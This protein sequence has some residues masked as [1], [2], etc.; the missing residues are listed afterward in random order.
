MPKS[1]CRLLALGSLVLAAPAFAQTLSLLDARVVEGSAG[2]ALLVFEAR[3][4]APASGTVRFDFATSDGSATY[5]STTASDDYRLVSLG[6]LS[7][8]AGQTQMLVSVPV[9]GDLEVE[10]N[11][12]LNAAIYNVSGATVARAAAKGLIVNDDNK[13]LVN[14]PLDPGAQTG[15]TGYANEFSALSGDGRYVAFVST[16]RDLVAGRPGNTVKNV[17]VRDTRTGITTLASVAADG[18]DTDG[19]STMPVLSDNGRYLAF[20][21]MATNIA[22]NDFNGGTDVFLRDLQTGTTTLVSVDASGTGP[23]AGWSSKPSMSANGRFVAFHSGGQLVAGID[24]YGRTQSYVRDVQAGTTVL[25]SRDPYGGPGA[26][27]EGG[28]APHLSSDGRYVSYDRNGSEPWRRD[29][30]AGTSTIAIFTYGSGP[31]GS[32]SYNYGISS[33]GRYVVFL[34]WSSN[35]TNQCSGTGGQIFVSD[36]QTRTTRCASMFS[37]GTPSYSAFYPSMSRDGRYVAYQA[38]GAAVGEPWD[39]YSR[40]FVRDM[41]ANTTTL[42]S[43]NAQGGPE[44]GDASEM[45]SI[46]ADGRVVSFV[47]YSTEMLPGDGNGEPDIFRVELPQDPSLPRISIADASV[48][49]GD[50]GTRQMVFTVSLSAPSASTVAFSASVGGGS[51][52]DAADYLPNAPTTY[53]PAGQTSATLAIEV[54]GDTTPELVETFNVYINGAYGAIV[55][56]GQAAGIIVNDDYP[57][58]PTLSIADQ[59]VVEGNSGTKLAYLTV[60][61]SSP[62]ATP[63][64]FDIATAN[65]TAQAGSDFVAATQ[66]LTIPAGSTSVDFGVA[67]IGDGVVESPETFNVTISNPVGATISRAM[68]FC[69]IA[70]DDSYPQISLNNFSI[71]EGN[72]GTKLATF[73]L[74]LS[75]PAASP[76]TYDIATSDGTAMAG[77][78]YVAR[79]LTGQVIP[80]GASSASFSVTV[81]G[82]TTIEDDETFFATL[83]NVAGATSGPAGQGRVTLLNDDHIESLVVLD[84]SVAEGNSGTRLATFTVQ[85]SNPTAAPVSFTIATADGTAIAPADYVA[86]SQSFQIP[87]G[88]QTASFAVTIN[89][90][91]AI[92]SN[93]TFLVNVSGVSGATVLDGQAVGTI[94]NDDVLPTLSIADVSISEGNNSSKNVTFMVS[95]SAA[96]SGTVSF[97]IATANGTAV[98]PGDYTAKTATAQTIPAGTL[99]KT[100][101]VSIKGDKQV[102][103]TESFFVNLSNVSGPVTLADGQ[104]IGTIVNDDGATLSVARVTTG[105]LYDDVDDHR[106]DPVLAPREYALL[107]LDAAQQVCARAGGATIVGIDGVESMAVLAD[108]ADTANRTC[109]RQPQYSA[110]LKANG[111]GFLVERGTQVLAVSGANARA[112]AATVLADGHARPLTVLLA[113]TPSSDARERAAQVGELNRLVRA[114][115]AAE[116]RARLVVLGATGIDGLVDLT[117]RSLPTAGGDAERIWVSPAMLE[118]FERVQLDIPGAPKS[119]PAQQVLQLQP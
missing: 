38:R 23:S 12:F 30:Q 61:L 112:S 104:A 96:A 76:V 89:G 50:S 75:S 9:N 46:S 97:N 114:R 119:K 1:I 80:V 34:S 17:Y 21:S 8:P 28:Y 19:D 70:N 93:E 27:P 90:D 58:P 86:K 47:S 103:P 35:L 81:N 32:N 7:I 42:A 2:D 94:T 92:E 33:D 18:G 117:A 36:L 55:A 43:F 66:T 88:A 20:Q 71:A 52:S 102:E 110:A 13:M 111:L 79:A 37:D 41:Q 67:I 56:D 73:T 98:A 24:T 4:S 107:L 83:S 11:E 78:D 31:I 101:T 57:P 22:A 106:G 62:S 49:E 100:F 118:E 25:A 84:A 29:L 82:D 87:A 69:T 91:T 116:P 16:G 99:G 85:L 45:A 72:S 64:S 15:S 40:I 74:T 39:G 68:A 26:D 115:L 59:F 48:L 63:V 44:S 108:L 65:N 6:A 14:A 77:S 95:L 10:A 5:G 3:L 105:G 60:S 54:Y 53:I 51:A 109:A 113:A